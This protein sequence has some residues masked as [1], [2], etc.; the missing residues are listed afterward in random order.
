MPCSLLPGDLQ[1]SA[2][3]SQSTDVPLTTR[4][5]LKLVTVTQVVTVCQCAVITL[6]TQAANFPRMLLYVCAVSICSQCMINML[7]AYRNSK[8]EFL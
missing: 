1:D 7:I 4:Q 3:A 5:T 2:D 6:M 8:K